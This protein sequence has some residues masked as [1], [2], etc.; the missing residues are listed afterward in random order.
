MGRTG[1]AFCPGHISGY[2]LPVRT[3]EPVTS[4]SSGAGIVISEGVTVR[5]EPS[6]KP[7][8]VIHRVESPGGP[9]EV[10]M[11]SPP[12]E[13]AME[14]LGVAAVVS[15]TCR[16]P[17]GAGYGLSAAAL[18]ASVHALNR[19]FGLGLTPD[20]CTA[21]AHEAEIVHRTGLGD[22]AACQGG[23]RDCRTGPGI[24]ARIERAFDLKEPLVA[25]TFGQLLSPGILG[26]DEKMEQ[27]RAAY[28]GRCPSDAPDFFR[29]SRSFAEKSG[30]I[31]REV[32]RALIACDEA[33]VLASMTML[34][35]G[36]FAYGKDASAVLGEFGKPWVLTTASGGT[37]LF[38]GDER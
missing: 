26:S 2:F 24:H 27:V 18:L 25:V 23:G 34:G 1:L 22:V 16:L 5:V 37:T 28:P 13:Y 3:G 10:I 36:V 12:I 20:T 38:P 14:R 19:L 35:N 6:E 30:L 4:G 31:T 33:A 29:L 11:G 15:T 21:Y 17:I 32:R 8:V 9:E 7:E